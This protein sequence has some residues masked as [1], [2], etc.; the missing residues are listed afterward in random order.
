[1]INIKIFKQGHLFV[2]FE[3]KGHAHYAESGKD[4]VCSAVTSIA[5][6][7]LNAIANAYE[8][9]LEAFSYQMEEGLIAL[10][11]QRDVS[12]L[13]LQ[14]ILETLAIQ[15]ETVANAQNKYVKIIKQEVH[16]Q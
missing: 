12:N 9:D 10:R 15:F 8:N 14:A 6:G 1:M 2:G 4:I 7:G 16:S 13:K 5:V 3:C 11:I